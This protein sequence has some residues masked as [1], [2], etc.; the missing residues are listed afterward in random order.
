[1]LRASVPET[2]IDEYGKPRTWEDE[3]GAAWYAWHGA[4]IHPVAQPHR[5]HCSSQ[6]EFGSRV[7][8]PVADHHCSRRWG[9]GP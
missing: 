2:A 9:A 5:V 6:P 3:I 4:P 1:M 7:T 8:P